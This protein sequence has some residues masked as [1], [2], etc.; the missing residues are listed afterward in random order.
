M[1]V[2]SHLIF[3]RYKGWRDNSRKRKKTQKKFESDLNSIVRGSVNHKSKKV[4]LEILKWFTK[5]EKKLP[6]FDYRS[7]IVSEAKHALFQGE[8][9]T[10]LTPK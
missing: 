1:V 7:I 4:H 9:L 8:W 2:N 6:N 5:H 3:Q 10:I